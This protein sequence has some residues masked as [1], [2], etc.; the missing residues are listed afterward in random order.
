MSFDESRSGRLPKHRLSPEIEAELDAAAARIFATMRRMR[1]SVRKARAEK[2]IAP[3]E[4]KF[5]VPQG[6]V[7]EPINLKQLRALRDEVSK[8]ADTLW[9]LNMVGE[10]PPSDVWPRAP[11]IGSLQNS[12]RYF[13]HRRLRMRYGTQVTRLSAVQFAD[14]MVFL[15]AERRTCRTRFHRR[16][17]NIDPEWVLGAA[18]SAVHAMSESEK[19]DRLGAV[20]Y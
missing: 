8:L 2:A 11:E 1:R 19:E 4:V 3:V 5:E 7:D 20:P 10:Y 6:I 17:K 18:V 14:A 16:D 12:L 13:V 9:S 15:D